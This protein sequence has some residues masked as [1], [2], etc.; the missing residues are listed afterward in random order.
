[1][2]SFWKNEALLIGNTGNCIGHPQGCFVF[3]DQ[4]TGLQYLPLKV[5]CIYRLPLDIYIYIDVYRAI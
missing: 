2:I 4:D 5:L 3:I 1:M